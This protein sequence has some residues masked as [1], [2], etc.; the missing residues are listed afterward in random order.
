MAIRKK[1]ETIHLRVNPISKALLE[2]LANIGRK[3]ST[4]IIEDLIAYAAEK[5][6]IADVEDMINDQALEDGE[7]RLKNA[8]IAAQHSE[9]AILTKLRTYYLVQEALSSRDQTI[10][11]A[12]LGSPKIFFGETAIFSVADK[13]INRE[14][15]PE[16]PKVNVEKISRKMAILE[17][18]AVFTEKNPKLHTDF[19]AFLTLIGEN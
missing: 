5:T 2:G 13:M 14:F 18:F 1:S 7:L 6:V 4:Q 12:I 9:D 11:R 16:I 10:S 17:E 19:S 3:T 15:L 8:L